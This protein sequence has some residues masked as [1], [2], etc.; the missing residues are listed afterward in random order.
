MIMEYCADTD[1]QAKRSLF[2]LQALRDVVVDQRSKAAQESKLSPIQ[3]SWTLLMTCYRQLGGAIIPYFT[4]TLGHLIRSTGSSRFNGKHRAHKSATHINYG[5]WRR[6]IPNLYS[7]KFSRCH[8]PY[9]RPVTRTH[10]SP[11]I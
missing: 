3:K 9:V 11:A 8:R 4:T 2:I 7:A 5:Q 6:N 1:I 10:Q